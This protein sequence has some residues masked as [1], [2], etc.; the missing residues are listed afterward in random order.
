MLT[1]EL[2]ADLHKY[3]TELNSHSNQIDIHVKCV[4]RLNVMNL[5][6]NYVNYVNYVGQSLNIGSRY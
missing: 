6:V 4:F 5:Y 1:P 2:V 3:R